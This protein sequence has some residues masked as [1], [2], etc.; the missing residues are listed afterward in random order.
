MQS[1][2][3]I[4]IGQARLPVGL[5]SGGGGKPFS[6]L[7]VNP[8][9]QSVYLAL[10]LAAIL[11]ST[12]LAT[13]AWAATGMIERAP[14]T[15]ESSGS[16]LSPQAPRYGTPISPHTGVF[17]Q[18]RTAPIRAF[19]PGS[20]VLIQTAGGRHGHHTSHHHH[21]RCAHFWRRLVRTR[22]LVLA[23]PVFHRRSHA[24]R[25]ARVAFGPGSVVEIHPN[26]R[27]GDRDLVDDVSAGRTHAIRRNAYKAGPTV[28]QLRSFPVDRHS[29]QAALAAGVTQRD[30]GSRT[31]GGC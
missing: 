11:L 5:V 25:Q 12:L 13:Q 10:L 28:S 2:A 20:S 23:G 30:V 31:H 27:R 3:A 22:T 6:A 15:W 7:V 21:S 24:I 9:F 18:T 29:N 4:G 1:L 16:G 19:A 26:H 8:L 14:S 17:H